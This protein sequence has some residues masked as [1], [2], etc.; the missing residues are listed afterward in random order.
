MYSREIYEKAMAMLENRRSEANARAAALHETICA[1][2]PRVREIEAKMAESSGKVVSAVL[3]G[4]NIEQEV[5]HIKAENLALQVE[6]S[7]LLHDHGADVS[8]F[9]PQYT[10]G[11]CHD[12]GFVNGKRCACRNNCCG[13]YRVWSYPS[14]R[15]CARYRLMI[16]HWNIILRRRTAAPVFRRGH[17]CAR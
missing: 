11:M 2:V 6:L 12:T 14:Y 10:C 7:M 9:E 16:Y 5:E 15:P 4:G 3:R 17:V 1:A 8:N 13:N